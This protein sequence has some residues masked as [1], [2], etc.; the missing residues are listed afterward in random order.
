MGVVMDAERWKR[1]DD[2]LQSVLEVPDDQQEESLR[3]ACAGD[4]LLEQEVHSLLSSH[5]KLGEFLQSPAL[6]VLPS[7]LVSTV[8]HAGQAEMNDP[9]LGQTMSHYRVLRPLGRGGMGR[10]ERNRQRTERHRDF[11]CRG[12]LPADLGNHQSRDHI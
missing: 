7:Q 3:Q 1:V 12:S 11:C 9:R 10:G 6:P 5:R 8:S 4:A 2:L